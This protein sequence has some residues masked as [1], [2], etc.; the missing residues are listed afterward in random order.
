MNGHMPVRMVMAVIGAVTVG[1]GTGHG[2]MLY[3]N[4]T[5]VY[6]RKHLRL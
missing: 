5:G 2:K 3:Y 1:V 6:K 4:I